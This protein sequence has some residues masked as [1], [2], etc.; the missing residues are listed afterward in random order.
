M[1]FKV[2][3]Y[4]TV[5]EDLAQG[6]D[7]AMM[8]HENDGGYTYKDTATE[9]MVSFAQLGIRTRIRRADKK[10]AL[11]DIGYAWVDEMFQEYLDYL[12]KTEAALPIPSADELFSFIT[13]D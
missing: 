7:Y 1:F 10:Y 6:I 3:D 9:E 13:H 11:D 8:G 4:V 2:G 12:D 5:R